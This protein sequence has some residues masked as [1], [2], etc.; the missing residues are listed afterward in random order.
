MASYIREE[1]VLYFK[2][3]FPEWDGTAASLLREMDNQSISTPI[4]EKFFSHKIYRLLPEEYKEVFK[5]YI[6]DNY[7]QS[8]SQ[9]SFTTLKDL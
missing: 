5:E 4:V 8:N 6:G 9:L 7:V 2:A 1:V 3:F